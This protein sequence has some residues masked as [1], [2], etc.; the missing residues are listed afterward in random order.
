MRKRSW[1][2]A[3][4]PC[5]SAYDCSLFLLASALQVASELVPMPGLGKSSNNQANIKKPAKRP[6]VIIV[7]GEHRKLEMAF[8]IRSDFT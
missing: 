6:S 8:Q 5:R 1:A 3:S 2:W 4:H 7:E